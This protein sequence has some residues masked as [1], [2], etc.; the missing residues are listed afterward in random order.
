M[1][2][3]RNPLSYLGCLGLIGIF[4]LLSGSPHL[5]AFLLFFLFFIYVGVPADELFWQNVRRAGLR[6]FTAVCVWLSAGTLFTVY[7]GFQLGDAG[8]IEPGLPMVLTLDSTVTLSAGLYTQM[9]L[10]GILCNFGF[11]LCIGIFVLTLMYFTWKDKKYA[12]E[13]DPC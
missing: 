10:D 6:A 11:F 8:L 2:K 1:K 4:G 13:D 12:G 7:R 5:L 3:K 9:L